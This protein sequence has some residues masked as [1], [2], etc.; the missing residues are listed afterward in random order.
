[1]GECE[2]WIKERGGG[3]GGGDRETDLINLL[4]FP[5]TS[6]R[7]SAGLLSFLEWSGALIRYRTWK[8]CLLVIFKISFENYSWLGEVR[9]RYT[10]TMFC[11]SIHISHRV[12]IRIEHSPPCVNIRCRDYTDEILE[13]MESC[14]KSND[15][16]VHTKNEARSW[17]YDALLS[18]HYCREVEISEGNKDQ[19]RIHESHLDSEIGKH[20][21]YDIRR[22]RGKLARKDER[23]KFIKLWSVCSQLRYPCPSVVICRFPVTFFTWTVP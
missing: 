18:P 19:T 6:P 8:K 14:S 10:L 3:G 22:R 15:S 13:D 17:T 12:L 9:T 11:H 4:L 16:L 20:V 21:M 23:L 5:P 2:S 7:N 1:M